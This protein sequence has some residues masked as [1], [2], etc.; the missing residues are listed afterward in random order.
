MSNPLLRPSD[1][2]FQRPPLRDAAGNNVFAD[3]DTPV[4]AQPADGGPLP[5]RVVEPA[6]PDNCFAAPAAVPGSEPAY[7][8]QYVSTQKHRGI[9]LLVLAITG[10]A[11]S[12]AVLSVLSGLFVG[13]LGIVTIVPASIAAVGARADLRAMEQGAIDPSGRTLTRLAMWLALG[14]I[15]LHVIL[16]GAIALFLGLIGIR[17]MQDA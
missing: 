11:G 3:P 15:T 9:L 4:P 10:L 8:P 2:R 16:L 1:P 6:G 5:A 12:G 14:S 17:F 13:L 7:R